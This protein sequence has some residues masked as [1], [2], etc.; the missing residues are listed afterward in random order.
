MSLLKIIKAQLGLSGTPGNNFCLDASADNGTMKL[1]RGNAGA[2]T[3]DVMTVDAAGKVTFPIGATIKGGATAP[4]SGMIGELLT[5]SGGPVDIGIGAVPGNLN[6][7]LIPAGVWDI[8]VWGSFA[9]SAAGCNHRQICGSLV[10]ATLGNISNVS[11]WT[12]TAAGVTSVMSGYTSRQVFTVPTIV[13][14]VVRAQG[15]SGTIN[16]TGT[17]NA[18]RVA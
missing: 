1:A 13:F 2:T 12:T 3:Q 8:Q 11:E 10:S 7:L 14:I 16:A 18:R 15:T 17:I 5:A 9:P 6:S 4:A